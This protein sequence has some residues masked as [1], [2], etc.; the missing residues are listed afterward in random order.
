MQEN[1]FPKE[2]DY[3]LIAYY[4]CILL[5]ELKIENSTFFKALMLFGSL[6][7]LYLISQQCHN[8][9]GIFLCLQQPIVDLFSFRQNTNN[10]LRDLL[11]T[12][13]FELIYLQ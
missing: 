11:V 13:L 7:H 3:F 5:P 9:N 6:K 12:F 1:N 2:L 8:S 10:L 4:I